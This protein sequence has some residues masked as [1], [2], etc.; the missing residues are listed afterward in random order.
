M[1]LDVKIN[2]PAH[3][4]DLISTLAQVAANQEKIEQLHLANQQLLTGL[5]QSICDAA[6]TPRVVTS[7]SP[8]DA[9]ASV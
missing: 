7:A 5:A 3:L 6:S 9:P 2:L 4:D 8:R 1:Q